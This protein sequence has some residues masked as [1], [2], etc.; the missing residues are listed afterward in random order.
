METLNSS[1]DIILEMVV[2]F[3]LKK[4]ILKQNLLTVKLAYKVGV[5]VL[6]R[7]DVHLKIIKTYLAM[8]TCI[9]SIWANYQSSHAPGSSP[10]YFA[11]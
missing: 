1:A 4:I 8:K 3:L 9:N 5:E 11:M 6:K 7:A 10:E 2:F